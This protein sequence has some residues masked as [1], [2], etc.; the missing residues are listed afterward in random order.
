MKSEL[1]WC[2]F[3]GSR[4]STKHQQAV[5]GVFQDCLLKI[6]TPTNGLSST[7]VLATVGPG[8]ESIGYS[9]Q[10]PQ[11]DPKI[12]A[13]GYFSNQVIKVLHIES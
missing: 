11:R 2:V 6:G 8:L 5:I 9:H 3:P 4:P 10:F 13:C 12:G 7:D 1:R